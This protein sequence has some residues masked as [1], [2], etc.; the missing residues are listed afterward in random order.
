MFMDPSNPLAVKMSLNPPREDGLSCSEMAGSIGCTLK[1]LHQPGMC[2]VVHSAHAGDM[3]LGDFSKIL[4]Q[5]W[6]WLD[7]KNSSW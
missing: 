7:E 4:G 1:Q 5:S 2:H 6:G 3:T